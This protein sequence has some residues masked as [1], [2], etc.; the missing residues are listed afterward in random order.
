VIQVG[1]L[2][3]VYAS[4]IA[5]LSKRPVEGQEVVW[6][7]NGIEQAWRTTTNQRG[8]TNENFTASTVGSMTIEVQIRDPQQEIFDRKAFVFTVVERS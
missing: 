5:S 3:L 2:T 1:E 8:E 6:V 7:K 4:V